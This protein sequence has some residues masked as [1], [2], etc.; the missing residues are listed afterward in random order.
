ME[1]T[2]FVLARAIPLFS[3]RAPERLFCRNGETLYSE[4]MAGT[5]PR[6]S[7]EEEDQKLGNELMM[8]A[9]DLREINAHPHLPPIV[10]HID[11]PRTSFL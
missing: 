1:P 10:A 9:K 4:A 8:S 6:G 11:L 7:S 5:R 3:E 2:S